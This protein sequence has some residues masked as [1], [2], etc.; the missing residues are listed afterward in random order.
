VRNEVLSLKHTVS[1][2]LHPICSH[3]MAYGYVITGL[4]VDLF[5]FAPYS[6]RIVFVFFFF[7]HFRTVFAA[8]LQLEAACRLRELCRNGWRYCNWQCIHNTRTASSCAVDAIVQPTNELT[9]LEFAVNPPSIF[10]TPWRQWP[11]SVGVITL[12]LSSHVVYKTMRGL[13]T[14][15]Q[16]KP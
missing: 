8:Q 1:F 16:Y 14:Y 10:L 5:C 4:V 12:H 3:L 15:V 2:I 9:R 13:V 11:I 7:V 6:Y